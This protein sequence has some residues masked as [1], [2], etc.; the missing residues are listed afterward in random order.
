MAP[1]RD[2]GEDEFIRI[3]TDGKR[4]TL[5]Y[6]YRSGNGLRNTDEIEIE[7]ADYGKAVGIISRLWKGRKPYKQENIVEKWK[8]RGAEVDIVQ[9]PLIPKLVE[10]EGK[11]EK[12]VRRAISDLKITGEVLGNQ[13]LWNIFVRFGQKGKD[14]GDLEFKTRNR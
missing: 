8:Y 9:W 7:V 10:V 6:K 12:Q 13:S 11:D 5:T 3:R 1:N 14:M 2:P 4:T